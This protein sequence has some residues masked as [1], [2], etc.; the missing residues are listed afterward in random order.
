MKFFRYLFA[1][2]A[3]V[4]VQAIQVVSG[5]SLSETVTLPENIKALAPNGMSP[6]FYVSDGQSVVMILENK[7]VLPNGHQSEYQKR[8]LVLFRKEQGSYKEIDRS[9]K[10]IACSTC[11]NGGT[12]PFIRGGIRLD[13]N[14][15]TIEQ[16]YSLEPSTAIYNFI[17][18]TKIS[19]WVVV[20]AINTDVKQSPVTSEFIKAPHVLNFPRETL[21]ANFNPNWVPKEP[22]VAITVDSNSEVFSFLHADDKS[23][24]DEKVKSNCSGRPSCHELGRQMKGCIALAKNNKKQF[25]IGV[26]N[27]LK[28]AG[29][30]ESKSKAMDSCELNGNNAC[31]EVRGDCVN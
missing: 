8:L 5:A 23:E 4:G 12:D 13:K 31:E 19:R 11:G 30:S 17:Y 15:L 27:K 29:K 20:S 14:N 22:G 18:N 26:S 16:D 1:F 10:I 24:L 2:T 6:I 28:E 7:V 21:L 25:F 3:G 9:D